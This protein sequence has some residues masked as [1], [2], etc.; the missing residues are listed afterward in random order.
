MS[1]SLRSA[2]PVMMVKPVPPSSADV[3][4]SLILR[5]GQLS[6]RSEFSGGSHG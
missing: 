1:E 2:M 6:E 3:P 4:L 5:N